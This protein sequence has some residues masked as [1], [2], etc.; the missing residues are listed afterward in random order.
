L[1]DLA[2]FCVKSEDKEKLL[3]LSSPNGKVE[4]EAQI[5]SRMF[6]LVD[7]IENYNL[8]LDLA[9]LINIASL[10]QVESNL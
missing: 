4:F 1:K 2:E 6:G 10:I 9:N 8:K 5:F 3:F 7:I